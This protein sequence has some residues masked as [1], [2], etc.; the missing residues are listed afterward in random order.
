MAKDDVIANIRRSL[1]RK[2][3]LATGVAP[4][5]ERRFGTAPE[6]I[7]PSYDEPLVERFKRKALAVASTMADVDSSNAIPTAVNDYLEQHKLPPE[8]VIAEDEALV[9]AS[10]SNSITVKRGRPADEDRVSV[11]L[12]FA[13]IAESGTVVMLSSKASPTTLNFMPVHH[14]VVLR[15]SDIVAYSEDVWAKL[16]NELGPMPRTVNFITGPS[17]TGDVEQMLQ[18]GAHGPRCLHVLLIEDR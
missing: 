10:W 7:Q 4:A 13:G 1:N 11:T 9:N 16:R 8:I 6:Q 3:P 14:I 15:A 2:G 5:L 18:L 17:R 12:A